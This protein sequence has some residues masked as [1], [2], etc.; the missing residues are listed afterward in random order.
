MRTT[1]MVLTMI[2]VAGIAPGLA[3]AATSCTATYEKCLN[4]TWD[5]KGVAQYL[6]NL[7]CGA[8]YA[9]CIRQAIL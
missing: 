4:D 2:A 1:A 3:S 6:A 8:R 9:G 7:E 5:M